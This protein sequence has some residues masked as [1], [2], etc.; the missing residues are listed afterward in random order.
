M[1]VEKRNIVMATPSC[2]VTK[3]FGGGGGGGNIHTVVTYY[4]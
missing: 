4:E 1:C 2:T 3:L